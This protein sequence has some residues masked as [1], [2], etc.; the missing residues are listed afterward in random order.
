MKKKIKK[1]RIKS[2]SPLMI[3]LML[4][5]INALVFTTATYGVERRTYFGCQE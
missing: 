4:M 2:V 3:A 1:G 5:I